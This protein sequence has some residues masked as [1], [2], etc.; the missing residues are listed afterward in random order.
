MAIT[1][2]KQEVTLNFSVCLPPKTPKKLLTI[3][4]VPSSS[5]YNNLRSIIREEDWDILRRMAYKR[6]N[7]FCEV[8]HGQGPEWPVE[9]HEIWEYDDANYIQTLTG[10]I[11]LCPN[12]HQVKHIGFATTRGKGAEA[13]V[14]LQKI[15]GWTRKRTDNYIEKQFEIWRERSNYYWDIH[16]D[17]L[18]QFGIPFKNSIHP[19]DC[20][21]EVPKP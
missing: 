3:E 2:V 6:A 4:L 14:Y 8:C 10:L 19:P 21:R 9:C 20:S 15:N 7:Y 1:T 17:W 12:C 13:A 18:K 5:W 16:L 11:A